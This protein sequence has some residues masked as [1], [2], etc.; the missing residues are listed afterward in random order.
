MRHPFGEIAFFLTIPSV[1]KTAGSIHGQDAATMV[2]KLAAIISALVVR[3]GRGNRGP[4]Q[5]R[6]ADRRIFALTSALLYPKF[7]L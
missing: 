2:R 3:A 6:T 7:L 5:N 1:L 4:R